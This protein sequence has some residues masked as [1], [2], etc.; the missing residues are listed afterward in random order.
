MK[1]SDLNAV[2]THKEF[3]A[4]QQIVKAMILKAEL[5]QPGYIDELKGVAN[6]AR[7]SVDVD[8]TTWELLDHFKADLSKL[9]S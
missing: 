4:L 6:M 1:D 8:V 5:D 9:H 3:L 7:I 2:F